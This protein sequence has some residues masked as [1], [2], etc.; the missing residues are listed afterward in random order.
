MVE[1]RTRELIQRAR[2]L[3]ALAYFTRCKAMYVAGRAFS[4]CREAATRRK[5]EAG[6]SSTPSDQTRH[7]RFPP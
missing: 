4:L 2:N 1:R 5:R 7:G 6:C 3:E